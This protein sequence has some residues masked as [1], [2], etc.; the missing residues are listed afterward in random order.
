MSGIYYEDDMTQLEDDMTPLEDDI[1]P[2]MPSQSVELSVIPPPPQPFR[3]RGDTAVVNIF[4]ATHGG[5]STKI[6]TRTNAR[7]NSKSSA[8]FY[9]PQLTSGFDITCKLTQIMVNETAACSIHLLGSI[10]SILGEAYNE[11]E[12]TGSICSEE[13]V[14]YLNE[15]QE[16]VK[17]MYQ[18]EHQLKVA[19]FKAKVVGAEKPSKS[20]IKESKR[21][22]TF[23]YMMLKYNNDTPIY[24]KTYTWHTGYEAFDLK[25]YYILASIFE[26]E[27]SETIYADTTD[28]L[29]L[30]TLLSKII[31]FYERKDITDLQINIVDTSCNDQYLRGNARIQADGSFST[32]LKGGK[33]H[34]K[35]K[36]R[37]MRKGTKRRRKTRRR[38]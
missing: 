31:Y 19:A 34:K 22:G 10:I 2:H 1:S 3:Y 29:T 37:K 32:V 7:S 28:N 9:M 15:D 23:E 11:Y 38:N 27:L 26:A 33:K 6:Q 20:D 18:A 5:L 14:K 24:N 12:K 13:V 21:R 25:P 8:I 17:D 30:M 4:I 16:K 36:K 35:T